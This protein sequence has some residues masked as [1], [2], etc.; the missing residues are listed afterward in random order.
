MDGA[1]RKKRASKQALGKTRR[2]KRIKKTRR[3]KNNKKQQMKTQ[4]PRLGDVGAEYKFW[5]VPVLILQNST[6][7]VQALSQ[8]NMFDTCLLICLRSTIAWCTAHQTTLVRGLASPVY[9]LSVGKGP[10]SPP[11]SVF[12]RIL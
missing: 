3:T 1:A 12:V 10:V 7:D 6:V 4:E 8:L 9:P 11:P 5:G 2:E